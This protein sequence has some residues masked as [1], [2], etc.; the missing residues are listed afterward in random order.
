MW[1]LDGAH[2]RLARPTRDIDAAVRFWVDGLG[3]T[4]QGRKLEDGAPYEELAFVGW[5]EAAWHLEI[6]KD[7]VVSPNPTEE[8]LL[9]LYLAGPIDE[10]LIGRIK[11]AGGA[12]VEARNPY[13]NEH[14]VTVEDPDGYRLVLSTRDWS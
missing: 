2:M 10:A 13:W 9:V 11:A 14:G 7:A 5:P 6:V 8:D 1:N 12:A 3:M 4:L